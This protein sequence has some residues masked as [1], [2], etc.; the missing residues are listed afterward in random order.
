MND[1]NKQ[2]RNMEEKQGRSPLYHSS[3]S[4]RRFETLHTIV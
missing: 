1:A 2:L 4:N 3:E